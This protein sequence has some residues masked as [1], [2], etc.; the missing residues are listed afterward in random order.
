[1]C[2]ICSDLEFNAKLGRGWVT[3]RAGHWNISH[4]A[5]HLRFVSHSAS[6]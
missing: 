3:N 5:S 6:C 2:Q 1:M 4:P